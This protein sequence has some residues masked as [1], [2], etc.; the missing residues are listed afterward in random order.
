M[1]RANAL[2]W[3]IKDSGERGNPYVVLLW[4]QLL[5]RL[6][7]IWPV[8]MMMTQPLVLDFVQTDNLKTVFVD[9]ATSDGHDP[10][11]GVSPGL[12]PATLSS[13]DSSMSIED[14]LTSVLA[15]LRR[16][17]SNVESKYSIIEH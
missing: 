2:A 13:Q 14:P 8:K 15:E 7:L 10:A 12:L 5:E 3:A 17:N 11:S 16:M 1:S 4:K 6:Y 9:P